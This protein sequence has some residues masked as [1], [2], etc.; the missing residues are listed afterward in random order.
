MNFALPAILV[1]LCVQQTL[2]DAPRPKATPT[3]VQLPA[4]PPPPPPGSGADSDPAKTNQAPG[5][6]DSLTVLDSLSAQ[7]RFVITEFLG[8]K[9]RPT[10][11]Q[12]W[13]QLMP[14]IAKSKRTWYGTVKNGKT[15]TARITF[16]L[17]R[18]GAITDIALEESSGDDALDRA[19]MQAVKDSAPLLLPSSFS[20]DTLS[21]RTAFMYNP[22]HIPPGANRYN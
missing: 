17:H 14:D 15:G 18:N 4:T 9:V 10:I 8:K 1:F 21:M 22:K 20:K 16:K 13:N 3:P 11:G 2:P 19:A 5:E 7:D 12:H 6:A